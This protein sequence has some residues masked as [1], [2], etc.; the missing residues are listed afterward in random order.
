MTN[1][2][3]TTPTQQM[4]AE[5]ANAFGD[6]TGSAKPSIT[7][8]TTNPSMAS[9]NVVVQ[10]VSEPVLP[11]MNTAGFASIS[12]HSN[13]VN[14]S[15]PAQNTTQTNYN[16]PNTLKAG[17]PTEMMSMLKDSPYPSQR[18]YAADCLSVC[19]WQKNPAIVD[20]LLS[21]ASKDPAPSVRAGCVHC[22]SK[23]HVN[24]LATMNT[25]QALKVDTDPR[26]RSE[27]EAALASMSR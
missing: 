1:A 3:T 17:S 21:A 20:C 8:N 26:V 2:F 25:L 12:S 24:N 22:L 14:Q 16:L 19:D 11:P 10:N 27:V 15:S 5:N 18:E 9:R 23:M 13:P 6:G 4:V 7:P